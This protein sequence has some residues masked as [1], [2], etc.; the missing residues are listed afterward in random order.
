MVAIIL[1]VIIVLVVFWAISIY[2]R[3]VK[4]RNLVKEAWSGIDVQL[5]RR[6]DLIPNLLETVKG[7][8]KHEE[9]LFEKVTELRARSMGAQGVAEQGEAEAALTRG[10]MNLFAVAE[11]YPELKAD[12][13]FR[14]LQTELSTLEDNI[15][16]ARR[17]YNG[18]ARDFNILIESFPSNLVANSFGFQQAEYFEIDSSEREVPEV[19][20]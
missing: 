8:A 20:F 15:Q 18:S 3:L 14:Q 9:G 19:K 5:K 10:L 2:N 1:L 12:Q 6:T 17:Y 11:N 4:H 16:M 7:Y 13:N